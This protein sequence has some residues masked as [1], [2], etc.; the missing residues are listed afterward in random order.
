VRIFIIHNFYQQAGGEDT[1]F[2]QDVQELGGRHEVETFTDWNARGWR[3][4]LQYLSYPW[5][6]IVAR[7]IA[8]RVRR[9]RPDVVHI[10]N[11]HYAIGPWIVRRLHKMGVP[12]V[13]TLHNYRLL[14]P[15]ATLLFRGKPFEDS[16]SDDFPRTA[17]RKRVL[18]GSFG[19][20]LL[21]GFAY[22]LHRKL[23][24]WHK[25]SIFILLSDF[26]KSLFE[27]SSFPVPGHRFVVKPNAV[28]VDPVRAERRGG[29]FIS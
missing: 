29:F 10:H 5:N 22:W 28:A 17:V 13:M 27:T 14:C 26:A 1:V 16:L 6:L 2:R 7:R 9:F 20:T 18:E 24:T 11:L 25:I 12:V 21:T 3:G 15:S 4:V 8:R 19:K 23:G